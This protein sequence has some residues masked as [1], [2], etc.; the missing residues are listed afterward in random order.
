MGILSRLS[1]KKT[2]QP[3]PQRVQLAATVLFTLPSSAS[4]TGSESLDAFH[5]SIIVGDTEFSFDNNGI[6]AAARLSS[7]S[8]YPRQTMVLDVG[9]S[10]VQREQMLVALSTHFQP[11]TYDLLR[12]NCNSFSECALFYLLGGDLDKRYSQMERLG[13]E[14]QKLIGLM[15]ILRLVGVNYR[16]NRLADGFD[17]NEVKQIL[18]GKFCRQPKGW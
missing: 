3:V 15:D 17:V 6:S 1:K 4:I 11:R 9:V 5:T 14:G 7:H 10:F 13:N 16:P 2:T 8:R 12:K 18:C